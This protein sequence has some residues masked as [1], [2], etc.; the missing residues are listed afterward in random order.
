MSVRA[1]S[2]LQEVPGIGE[3]LLTQVSTPGGNLEEKL[4]WVLD[5]FRCSARHLESLQQVFRRRALENNEKSDDE[6]FPYEVRGAIQDGTYAETFLKAFDGQTYLL[7][8][9]EIVPGHEYRLSLEVSTGGKFWSNIPVQ[10]TGTERHKVETVTASSLAEGSATVISHFG[11]AQRGA[12]FVWRWKPVLD[13]GPYNLP[14]WL[15]KA[16]GAEGN[17][18]L[19]KL[20]GEL[21]VLRRWEQQVKNNAAQYVKKGAELKDPYIREVL[22]LW[23]TESDHQGCDT[24]KKCAWVEGLDSRLF[25]GK[26]VLV[27]RVPYDV[28]HELLLHAAIA[29]RHTEDPPQEGNPPYRLTTSWQWS[30]P[31]AMQ[32]VFA[33]REHE[34]NASAPS[35]QELRLSS[36]NSVQHSSRSMELRP[37]PSG[38]PNT[39]VD[40]SRS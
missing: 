35:A 21:E 8:T 4:Q 28:G 27:A 7:H 19:R 20:Q 38:E 30:S 32:E 16:L 13:R 36:Q 14:E 31:A 6:P 5:I 17:D 3:D 24:L 15:E 26:N 9:E 10:D 18:P 25:V 40:Q 37:T 22:R 12:V 2:D 11:G 34:R 23:P 39:V 33:Q 29:K 1:N